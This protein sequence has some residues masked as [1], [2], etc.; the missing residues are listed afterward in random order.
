MIQITEY[1]EIATFGSVRFGLGNTTPS[2]RPST[3]KT[4]IGKTFVEKE[5]P[6]RNTT[7]THLKVQ[8]VLN[9]LS[10]EVGETEATAIERDRLALIAL[11]DGY[12][13]NYD[14]G[15]HSGDFAIVS[16]SLVWNDEAVREPG[17]PYKFTVEF[18]EWQ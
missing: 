13:H 4:N 3:L 16:R 5:I 14:D 12:K 18:I 1:N 8:G 11:A 2:G 17:E 15:R 6:L 7:D 9:G 10:R